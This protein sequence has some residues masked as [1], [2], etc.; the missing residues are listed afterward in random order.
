MELCA[1]ALL[2]LCRKLGQTKENAEAANVWFVGIRKDVKQD[3]FQTVSRE[4]G[5]FS[6]RER[7]GHFPFGV[8]GFA[9]TSAHEQMPA[10]PE[11]SGDIFRGL[12]AK[13]RRQNLKRVCFEN[14]IKPAAPILER[15]EETCGLIVDGGARKSFSAGANGGFRNVE[16]RG[17]KTP[18]PQLLG[19]IAKS[20][21]G[22]QRRFSL[23]WQR[24]LHPKA[25]KM[26]SRVAI[27]PRDRALPLLGFAVQNLKPAGGIALAM[28]FS[29]EF[30]RP[31]AVFHA[32]NYSASFSKATAEAAQAL[33]PG[34]A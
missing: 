7:P 32:R 30:A 2:R 21:P 5:D 3:F 15:F 20:A 14:E 11:K 8:G 26:R 19:I 1:A 33:W 16:C 13:R 22:Y 31:L 29:G 18:G 28:E 9:M 10:R 4:S 6:S 23:G 25:Y 27:I 24:M 12:R 34:L 17:V